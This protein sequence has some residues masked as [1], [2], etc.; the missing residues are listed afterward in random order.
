MFSGNVSDGLLDQW[1]VVADAGDVAVDPIGVTV[2]GRAF[3]LWRDA[4]GGIAAAPDRCPHREAPLSAGHVDRGCIVC[5]YHGWTFGADGACEL[6]PSAAPSTPISPMARLE[7]TPVRE[8]YGVI[9]LCPGT[10]A[11]DPPVIDQEADASYRR[12]T[13]GM[14]TWAVS[15]TRMTDNFCDVAHFPF[16]HAATIGADTDPVVD[17]VDIADLGDG[18]IGYRY[19]VDVL[20]ESGERITQ[21]M[22]TAFHLPFIVRSDTRYASGSRM[23]HDRVLLLCTTP[24]DDERSLFTFV[25]WR[26]HDHDEPAEELLAFDRA[27]GA[28]DKLMLEQI[29]GALSLDNRGAATVSVKADRLSVRWRQA[30]RALVLSPPAVDSTR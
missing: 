29:P 9:W 25:V 12:L 4:D 21:D 8:L 15:A 30:L 17:T 20:D 13:A 1:Y 10:P 19:S 26:N 5:P 18:F 14:Q 24:I 22:S 27:I 2:L 28:E 16:V 7:M 6:I 23:G 3:V 11:G